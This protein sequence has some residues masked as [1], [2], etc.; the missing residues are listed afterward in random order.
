VSDASYTHVTLVV[1]PSFGQRAKARAELGPLWVIR[2]P[3]NV[4]AIEA[5]WASGKS[6]FVDAPTVFN[7]VP[8]RSSEDAAYWCIGT[9]HDH[10]PAWRTFEVIGVGLSDK[11]LHAMREC[12]SGDAKETD[13]GFV[14]T[15]TESS[16]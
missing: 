8:G 9:V 11:L 12:A 3:D 4:L 2:S 1:D 10:H 5:I 7:A 13:E 6:P 15:R 16:N 14:F